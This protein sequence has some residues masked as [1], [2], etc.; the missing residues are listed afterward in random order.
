[1]GR[2]IWW[3]IDLEAFSNFDIVNKI[4]GKGFTYLYDLNLVEYGLRI[5][6]HNDFLTLLISTGWF[7][8]LGYLII[9]KSW[10]FK[11]NYNKRKLSD[12]IFTILLFI[13]NAMISGVY[14]AQQYI[15]CNLIISLVLLGDNKRRRGK[16]KM[17]YIISDKE[18]R[19]I[20]VIKLL[21]IVLVLYIHAF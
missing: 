3:K 21:S 15:F 17:S 12:I 16:R 2:L 13:V 10:F 18:S 19:L 20:N 8:L 11:K 1:M 14:G 7:G 4:F 5:S 9:L 6:A